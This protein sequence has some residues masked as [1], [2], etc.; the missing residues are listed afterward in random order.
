MMKKIASTMR[1]IGHLRLR[2]QEQG[3]GS[4]GSRIAHSGTSNNPLTVRC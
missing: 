3:G 4:K 1:R 2:P